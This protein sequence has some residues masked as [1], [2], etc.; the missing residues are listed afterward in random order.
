[1][2]RDPRS[3]PVRDRPWGTIRK[4]GMPHGCPESEGQGFTQ[5][6]QAG[7]GITDDNDA[8]VSRCFQAAGESEAFIRDRRPQVALAGSLTGKLSK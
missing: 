2:R 3:V 4:H 1:M 8:Q 5:K 6:A 7:A